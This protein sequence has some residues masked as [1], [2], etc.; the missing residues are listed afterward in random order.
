MLQV[1]GCRDCRV[2]CD[3]AVVVIVVNGVVIVVAFDLEMLM[4]FLGKVQIVIIFEV[5]DR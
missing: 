4:R 3:F 2:S 1:N 5:V